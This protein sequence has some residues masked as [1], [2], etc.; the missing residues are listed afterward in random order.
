MHGSIGAD[1]ASPQESTFHVSI[2]TVRAEPETAPVVTKGATRPLRVLLAEDNPTNR[3]V[4]LRIL[5]R[6]GH[7]ADAVEDGAG[8]VRA[9]TEGHYDIVLMDMMMPR[10]DGIAATRMIRAGAAPG[11]QVRIIGLT[12]NAQAS[13]RTACETAGMNGFLTKP[14]TMER[15][16]AVLAS[17]PPEDPPV[18]AGE[19]LLDREFLDRLADDI[20]ADG[21]AEVLRAF[22]EEGPARLEAIERGIADSHMQAVRREAHALAGAARNVGLTRLGEAAYA[23]QMATEGTASPHEA[24]A[25]LSSLLNE[26]LPLAAA[27]AAEHEVV[28]A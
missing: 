5:T 17:V 24:A 15:L 28:A 22:L 25:L 11:S 21:T 1:R 4:A 6:L 9:V 19:P 8:A 26:T 12:A 2:P 10:V 14:V 3:H 20:G 23:L 18:Q 13:D 16:R 7:Q 27:W